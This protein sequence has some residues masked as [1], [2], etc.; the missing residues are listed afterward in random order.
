MAVFRGGLD[1]V[2]R[3]IVLEEVMR[4]ARIE[5]AQRLARL[6]DKEIEMKPP[7][8]IID[9]VEFRGVWMTPEEAIAAGVAHFMPGPVT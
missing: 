4:R 5:E 2:M 6:R 1:E 3:S 7:E 9:M 8:A